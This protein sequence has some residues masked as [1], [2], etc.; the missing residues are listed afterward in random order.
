[1]FGFSLFYL[2]FL[3]LSTS[4]V[5]LFLLIGILYWL[6]SGARNIMAIKFG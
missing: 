6:L 1:V 3:S 4:L 5:H 2:L